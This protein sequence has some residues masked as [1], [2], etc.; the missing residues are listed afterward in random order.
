MTFVIHG[1]C[2]VGFGGFVGFF[3]DLLLVLGMP[4][5]PLSAFCLYPMKSPPKPPKP[6][7]LLIRTVSARQ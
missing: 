3:Y 4:L 5:L 7:N 1:V 6:L 2:C